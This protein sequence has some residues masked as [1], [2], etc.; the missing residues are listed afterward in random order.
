MSPRTSYLEGLFVAG[1]LVLVWLAGSPGMRAQEQAAS[2]APAASP[3]PTA[4]VA[5]T[6][7]AAM[8][9]LAAKMGD[10]INA[11]K[12]KSV[13]VLDFDDSD[14]K[15]TPLGHRF[16]EEFSDALTKDVVK[17]KLVPFPQEEKLEGVVFQCATPDS[18]L[19]EA[20]EAGAKLA[21][22]GKVLLESDTVT[23]KTEGIR[24]DNQKHT[25]AFEV[26]FPLTPELKELAQLPAK[27]GAPMGQDRNS[28]PRSDALSGGANGIGF[29]SCDYCPHADYSEAGK[30]NRVS[31]IVLMVALV[32]VD[33]RAR[34]IV[35]QKCLGYG[36]EE[37]AVEA[38]QKWRFK[39]ATDRDGKPVAVRV[40]IEVQFR[41][42]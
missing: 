20:K 26:H 37:K 42:Q 36:L 23:V 2:P 11:T 1:V 16:S 17:F 29:P 41:W 34:D 40:P 39:P 10:A 30:G 9:A 22:F 14:G 12:A 15:V 31:G 18:R 13:V 5:S 38:V 33:G 25:E 28:S 8:E 3:V 4:P 32:G 35:V 7:A 27:Q 6:E 19:S 21:V 24:A